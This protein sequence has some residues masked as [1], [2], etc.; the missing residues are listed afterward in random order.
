MEIT[1]PPTYPTTPPSYPLTNNNVFSFGCVEGK[2]KKNTPKVVVDAQPH[3]S[4]VTLLH[5]VR[6]VGSVPRSGSRIRLGMMCGPCIDMLPVL[7]PSSFAAHHVAFMLGSMV[8]DQRWWSLHLCSSEV[9]RRGPGDL[10]GNSRCA[11]SFIPTSFFLIHPT[12]RIDAAVPAEVF[13]FGLYGAAM[14]LAN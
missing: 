4:L 14:R 8:P 9:A 13:F 12:L 3:V 2:E 7:G 6:A 1:S 5:A 11:A 10:V